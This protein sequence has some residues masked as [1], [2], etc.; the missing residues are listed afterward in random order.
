MS[1]SIKDPMHSETP[2]RDFSVLDAQAIADAL[3][4]DF[5][6]GLPSSDVAKRIERE[7]PNTLRTEAEQP[8]WRLFTAQFRNPLVHVLG[9]AAVITVIVWEL[10]GGH[11]WP[12]DALV[13][14]VIVLLNALLGFFQESRS[15]QAAAALMS[16]TEASSAVLRDGVP[17][18]VPSAGLVRGDVLLLAEGD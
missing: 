16:L 5:S 1:L 8:A 6:T 15:R 10:G 7:G 9:A 3:G 18:R 13:I 4:V 11:G 14:G 12:V 2:S 17:L